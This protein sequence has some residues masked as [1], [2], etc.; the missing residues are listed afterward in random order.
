MASC[1]FYQVQAMARLDRFTRRKLSYGSS[2]LFYQDQ[3]MERHDRFTRRKLWLVK[4]VLPGAGFGS[5]CLFYQVQASFGTSSSIYQVQAT[6]CHVC[7]PGVRSGS[8]CLF[9]KDHAIWR[10]VRFTRCKQNLARHGRF[11]SCKLSLVLFV[12]PGSR[13]S[14][15]CLFLPGAR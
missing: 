13:Y 12:L 10:Y 8:S 3:A 2:S 14:L 5:S 4:S 7:F 9:Y 15:K 11:T 6:A 1:L